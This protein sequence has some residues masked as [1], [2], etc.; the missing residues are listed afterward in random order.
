M[1]GSIVIG[2]SLDSREFEEALQRLR[3]TAGQTA[4]RAVETLTRSLGN[5]ENAFYSGGYAAQKWSERLLSAFRATQSS[6]AAVVPQ[7]QSTGRQAGQSF[8][9]GVLQ[10]NYSGAGI[11]IG[12]RLLQGVQAVNYYGTGASMGQRLL[13]GFQ[14]VNGYSV[15][16]TLGQRVLQGVQAVNY[17]SV[18]LQAA[19]SLYRGFSA[20]GSS[21]S[22]LG[23]NLA[24]RVRSAFSG[25]WY[26]VGYYISAGI[27]SGIRGGS[28]LITAA[29]VQAAKQALAAAKRALGVRS[30]SRVFRD[31]VGRMIPA[32]IAQGVRQGGPEVEAVLRQQSQRL[33]ETARRDVRPA[34]ELPGGSQ[35]A[36]LQVQSPIR[37]TLEAPLVVDGRELARA[38]ARYTGQQ[39]LWETM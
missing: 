37:V 22:A 21:L 7:L 23:S 35:A 12:Q 17:Y 11:T 36:N 39:L 30:P 1:D 8:I 19:D 29:A 14:A 20:G 13:Q 18:G 33:V 5:L 16:T 34:L 27:A 32:G 38:T 9:S 6:A 31:Q 25:G 24:A 10:G 26:D 28:S 2:V 4:V 3:Q 15:G